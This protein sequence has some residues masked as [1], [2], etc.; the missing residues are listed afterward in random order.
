MFIQ[1]CKETKK[2]LVYEVIR[3]K[4]NIP[5]EISKYLRKLF[6]PKDLRELPP[7][8]PQDFSKVSIDIIKLVKPYTM[9]SQERIVTLEQAVRYVIQNQIEGDIV[10]C[11]VA[12]GGCM[13]VVAYVLKE[14]HDTGRE[15]FLYDTFEGTPE[16]TENDVSV[17]GKSALRKYRKKMKDGRS[18]WHYFPLDEVKNTFE[19][20]NYPPDKVYYVK[21]L[22]QETLPKSNHKKIALLRLDTNLYESTNAELTYLYP[23]LVSGG[24]III[25]DYFRWLGQRK[26]VDEYFAL[27]N[28]RIF[29]V[30]VD[31]HSV[32]GIKYS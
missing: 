5:R 2:R 12:L 20:T 21:G 22:V 23:K 16:P 14:L 17:F 11:G 30:R 3:L 13:M 8:Y 29:L 15:L 6:K 26:A 9:V 28:V 27:N 25:D 18:M 24:V 31:D 10:E 19:K 1:R 7:K 4:S 32:I